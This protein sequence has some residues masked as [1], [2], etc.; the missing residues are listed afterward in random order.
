MLLICYSP[1]IFGRFVSLVYSFS[2][3]NMT[4]KE[5]KKEA[6]LPP[7]DYADNGLSDK[8]LNK[9]NQYFRW[10]CAQDIKKKHKKVGG[11]SS[12]V[13]MDESLFGKLKYGKGSAS[14]RRRKWVFGG[15]C[16]ET[17]RVVSCSLP[18]KQ[19]HQEKFMANNSEEC[20]TW[21][22]LAHGRVES[23]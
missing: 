16:R 9:W 23:L 12:I 15:K 19:T 8:T 14:Q 20:E 17:G 21:Q 3:Q 11:R 2:A 6:R 18:Q 10:L 1:T 7:G 13:E 5:N 22:C 4:Y